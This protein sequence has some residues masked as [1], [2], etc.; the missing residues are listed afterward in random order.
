VRSLSV[1]SLLWS[2][3][4]TTSLQNARKVLANA[5]FEDWT[6]LHDRRAAF[7]HMK[8]YNILFHNWLRDN[9]TPGMD[10]CLGLALGDD[11][12]R[13]IARLKY[14]GKDLP[15]FQ[16][17]SF[18]PSRRIGPDG[19]QRSDIILEITQRRIGF[20]DVDRQK[21]VDLGNEPL[22]DDT[23]GDFSFRGGCTLI[24]D[25]VTW[26]I[27]Y[28]VRKSVVASQTKTPWDDARLNRERRFRQ[29]ANGDN[30]GG[31]YLGGDNRG[32]PFAFLHAS[33]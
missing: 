10:Q 31:I 1:D 25:P 16:V 33:H 17:D 15:V 30:V 5:E 29:G 22:T 28:C 2:P 8:Q 18:R 32:N 12:P 9:A 20:F 23:R 26:D 24:I 11:A 19:Q 3:P 13:S 14:K 27:R 7:L 6:V 21:A 4:E